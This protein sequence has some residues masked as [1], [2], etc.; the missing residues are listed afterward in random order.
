MA[1]RH[2]YQI[3]KLNIIPY[4]TELRSNSCSELDFVFHYFYVFYYS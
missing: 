3:Q 1:K 2:N 4:M